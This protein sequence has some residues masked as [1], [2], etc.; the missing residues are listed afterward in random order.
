MS[1]AD[2]LAAAPRIKSGPPCMTC[3]WL[4]GLD[5]ADQKAFRDFVAQPAYNR[6]LL[7]RVISEKWGYQAC[8]STLKYHLQ[9]HESR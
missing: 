5:E 4:S 2:D 8:E 6:A 7:H 1:L 3:A 9:F